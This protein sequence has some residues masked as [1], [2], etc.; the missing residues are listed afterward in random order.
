MSLFVLSF[1]IF[2]IAMLAMGL[3]LFAGRPAIRS[4]CG[5]INPTESEGANCEICGKDLSENDQLPVIRPVAQD[6]H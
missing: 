3:G 1:L 5:S 2:A 6:I 4:G